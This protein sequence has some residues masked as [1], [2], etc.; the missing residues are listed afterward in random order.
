[1]S[2]GLDGKGS[3]ISDTYHPK[4]GLPLLL[5]LIN[6][7]LRVSKEAARPTSRAGNEQ[8]SALI[9]SHRGLRAHL[10]KRTFIGDDGQLRE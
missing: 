1:M 9:S 6:T 5:L 10:H 3:N 7:T 2:A 8:V 4:R